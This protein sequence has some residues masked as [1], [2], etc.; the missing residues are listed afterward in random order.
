MIGRQS[1]KKRIMDFVE[2]ISET[3]NA[4]QISSDMATRIVHRT[5]HGPDSLFHEDLDSITP[6]VVLRPGSTNEVSKIVK[7]ANDYKTPIVVQG[8]RTGSYGA[9]AMKDCVVLDLA[10]MNKIIDFD[11][12]NYRIS[13][14]AG[15]RIKDYNEYLN[16]RGYMSIE[17]P[18]L[19]WTS[20]LGAR[21]G[22]SGYNKFENTW[23]GSAVAT[24]GIEVVL[25]NGARS[26]S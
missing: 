1:F 23:G 21:I 13:A 10:N 9:E 26:I 7:L 19:A 18:T 20:T 2:D 16:E 12:R 5:T 14:E 11:P 22:V 24:K 15:I 4:N 25:A 3:L 6:A 8:G 17:Y